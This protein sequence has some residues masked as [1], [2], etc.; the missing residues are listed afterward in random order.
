MRFWHLGMDLFCIWLALIVMAAAGRAAGPEKVSAENISIVYCVDC[1]PFHFQDQDGQPAGMIIDMWRK[2]S[3]ITGIDIEFRAAP[4]S[5]TLRIMS[6]DEVDAHA[7]LFFNAE[8]DRYLDYGVVLANLTALWIKKCLV[9]KSPTQV[10]RK[11][12]NR[13]TCGR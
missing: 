3:K 4:W 8:R 11:K 2:W 7:G 6:A 13:I 12:T 5:E 1:V 10:A 9:T